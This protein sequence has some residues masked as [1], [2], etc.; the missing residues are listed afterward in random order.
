MQYWADQGYAAGQRASVMYDM[1]YDRTKHRTNNNKDLL[2]TWL[3]DGI[4]R[5]EQASAEFS[6]A[7]LQ[8][9]YPGRNC[10]DTYNWYFDMGGP[11]SGLDGRP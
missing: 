11:A 5:C 6:L 10:R 7:A 9:R 1:E 4:N 8:R 2:N 3:K